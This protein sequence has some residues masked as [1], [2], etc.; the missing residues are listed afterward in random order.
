MIP[1]VESFA[2]IFSN[3]QKFMMNHASAL[4]QHTIDHLLESSNHPSPVDRL[5][6]TTEALYA[7]KGELSNEGRDLLGQMAQFAAVNGFHGMQ[8]RGQKINQAM[9]R[10]RGFSAPAGTSWPDAADDPKPIDRFMDPEAAPAAAEPT[11]EPAP[12]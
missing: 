4:P 3:L 10:M 8:D 7:V 6:N 5:V 12:E 1:P 9:N 2:Q 11:A